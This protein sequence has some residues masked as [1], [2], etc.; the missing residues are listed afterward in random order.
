MTTSPPKLYSPRC[1]V[2]EVHFVALLQVGRKG[3]YPRF[4][5]H[6]VLEAAEESLVHSSAGIIYT[7]SRG[8]ARRTSGCHG[9]NLYL[10]APHT[11][12]RQRVKTAML[13]N[14][15]QQH[16]Q[17]K[18]HNMERTSLVMRE[19]REAY[20]VPSSCPA[21][22]LSLEFPFPFPGTFASFKSFATF[23]QATQLY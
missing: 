5:A 19:G 15:K 11:C 8:S 3:C 6:G 23:S 21:L 13:L 20:P 9:A 18:K 16:A 14:T 1:H 17:H 4:L 22:L 12:Q 2:P 10:L 7:E